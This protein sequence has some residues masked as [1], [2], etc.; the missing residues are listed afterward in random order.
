VVPK[1]AQSKD[2][3]YEGELVSVEVLVYKKILII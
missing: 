1:I 3:D 2:L